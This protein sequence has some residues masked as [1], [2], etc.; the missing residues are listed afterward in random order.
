MKGYYLFAPVEPENAGPESGVE[1]KVR[2]QHRALNQYL[3]CE[4]AILP[5]VQ[6][7]GG[8]AEKIRRRLPLT[9]AWRKWKYGGEFNDADFLY[10]RQVYH[11]ASFVRW[12]RTL[13]RQNP[14]VKLV[15]EVPT[16]PYLTEQKTSRANAAFRKKEARW[17]PR[18]AKY[19]DRIVTFYG[20]DEIWGVPCLKLINGFDFSQV[21]LPERPAPKDVQIISVAATAFWHGY[22]RLIEGIHQYYEYGGTER[23]VYHVVGTILPG[24]RQMV[25]DY[26]LED[27]VIFHGRQSGEALKA[28]YAQCYLGVDVLGGHRKNY[29]VSSSLKSREYAAYGLPILTSSPV[30]YLPEDYK[31]QLTAPYDDSPVSA[32][33]ILSFFRSVYDENPPSSVAREIRSFAESYCDMSV[34]MKPV[35]EWLAEKEAQTEKESL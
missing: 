20:Q 5:P 7:S 19:M 8:I 21:E 31:Y 28:L 33:E 13:R 3:D 17:A 24:L 30:D 18:A 16:Y 12:L 15:Y 26:H 2:A 4:L 22:D 25:Q 1:R 6:Y 9:A 34:T 23:I 27:H 10:I 32:A 35:A 14:K 29:P 11:D